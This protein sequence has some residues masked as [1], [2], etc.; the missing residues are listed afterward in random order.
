[1]LALALGCVPDNKLTPSV[2]GMT[3]PTAGTDTSPP[4][5][6]TSD[7]STPTDTG[8]TPPDTDGCPEP[9]YGITAIPRVDRCYGD[10][11]VAFPRI[12]ATL[13][14]ENT[15]VG[16]LE[17]TVAVGQLTDD[18]GDGRVDAS[19]DVDI[20]AQAYF[21]LTLAMD[22]SG[23]ELWRYEVEDGASGLAPAIGDVDGDGRPDVVCGVVDQRVALRGDDGTPIW[24]VEDAYFDGAGGVAIADMDGDG[25]AEVVYG[26]TIYDGTDG[27]VLGSGEYGVGSGDNDVSGLVSAV[28]DVDGDG[29]QE[30]VVGNALYDMYGNE[31]WANGRSDGYVGVADFDGDL[32]A[33]IVVSGYGHVRLQDTDGTLIWDTF[34]FPSN[35]HGGPPVI[36]DFDGDGEPEIGVAGREE[37][38]LLD[39]DGRVFWRTPIQ[40]GSSGIA[41][42]SAFDFDGD[43]VPEI[44]Y[45]DEI[46]LY[47]FD[48]RTGAPRVTFADHSSG[49]LSEYPVV[50]DLDGDGHAEIIDT[51]MPVFSQ[52]E[53]GVRVLTD[54]HNAWP[55]ARRVWNQHAYDITNVDDGGGIPLSPTPNWLTYNSFRSADLSIPS[56]SSSPPTSPDLYARIDG[57]CV[58]EC[59]QGSVEVS[60]S[61]GNQGYAMVQTPFTVDFWDTAT[62]G[63]R[64]L[65]GSQ[66]WGSAVPAGELLG[67]VV[68]RLEG[69]T[70]PITHLSATI[71]GGD[72]SADGAVAECDEHNN[73]AEWDGAICE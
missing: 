67:S 61:V 2:D 50:V 44:V 72:G 62:D 16:A 32:Q 33:E 6:S 25:R 60:Y 52:E 23:R 4:A 19:D 45:A 36:A 13:L 35:P 37:Y 18:N 53:T 71:D 26:G 59:A 28:A 51:N 24:R 55:P 42:A 15:D 30:V 64:T 68:V 39:G 5:E 31:L 56:A 47:I 21:G 63:S 1:M 69:M 7:S 66:T 41:G 12:E 22:A 20:V 3:Q 43:G 27:S 9:A 40:D 73:T 29:Q 11:D 65:I 58:A 48:G 49:T 38:V 57:V 17:T 8:W 46:N 70:L 14:W 34:A 10:G 54:V